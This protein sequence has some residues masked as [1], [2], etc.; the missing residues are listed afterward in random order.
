[1]LPRGSPPPGQ[2][3][4][5]HTQLPHP[6]HPELLTRKEV[7]YEFKRDRTTVWRWEGEGLKFID[8][9][10]SAAAVVWFLEQRDAAK[11]LGIKPREF[12][13]KPREVRE[14]LLAAAVEAAAYGTSGGRRTGE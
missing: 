4:T 6:H 9:R 5:D 7:C 3:A 13:R 10:V 8:G 2:C 14:K 12:F 11:I 1:M